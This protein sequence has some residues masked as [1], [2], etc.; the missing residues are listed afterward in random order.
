MYIGFDQP[1]SMGGYAQGGSYAAPIFKDFAHAALA[2]RQPI[3][4]SAPKGVRMVRIDRQSGR[5]VYGAWPGTDPKA[6]II[7]EA[8]KPERSEEHTSELQSL[9]RISYAVFCVI[10]KT[11]QQNSHHTNHT[12]F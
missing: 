12:A 9:M 4:F 1:R 5:R 6:S 11:N 8:F 2:D 3:P 7:R 10:K